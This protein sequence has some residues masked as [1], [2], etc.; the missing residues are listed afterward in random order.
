MAV[1]DAAMILAY[2]AP[3]SVV[4]GA[5]WRIAVKLTNVERKLDK[6]EAENRE[7]RSELRALDR[8]L[9]VL[10]DSGRSSV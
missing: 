9:R 4:G 7:L 10:V 2:V 6:L 5:A 3:L 8:L 1:T